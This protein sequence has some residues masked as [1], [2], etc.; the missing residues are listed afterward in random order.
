MS[1]WYGW[2][3]L[4]GVGTAAAGLG[5]WVCWR[6]H[7]SWGWA[8]LAAVV[9][10]GIEIGSTP[11]RIRRDR[12]Q[13][14]H[15][16]AAVGLEFLGDIVPWASW[17]AALRLQRASC[18]LAEGYLDAGGGLLRDVD[19]SELPERLRPVWDVNYAY[20]LL[21]AEGQAAQSLRVLDESQEIWPQEMPASRAVRG[22]A[23]AEL[24]LLP[25]AATELAR[26]LERMDL[27]PAEAA[28]AYFHLATVWRRLGHEEYAR[29]QLVLASAAGGACLYA[30][31]ARQ[32]LGQES[33]S[34]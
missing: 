4:V 18:Y 17:K 16:R 20:Y 11:A 21:A 2:A 26:I 7:F 13:G 19:R 31:L 3:R 29:E 32:E 33:S 14:R 23:L 28:E 10:L 15:L 8:A 5:S 30:R 22:L 9:G 1:L 34:S 6:W 25:E 12:A 24:G 27:S